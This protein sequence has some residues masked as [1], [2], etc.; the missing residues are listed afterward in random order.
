[1]IDE[2]DRK[3]LSILLRTADTPKAEIARR[4]GLAPSAVSE[5][6]RKME[7]DGVIKGYETRIDPSQTGKPILAFMFVTDAKPTAGFDTAAALAQ[8]TGV[9]ELHKLAGEDCYLLKV[10]ASDIAELNTILEREVNTVP[11][12]IRVRTTIVLKS[13]AEG[14]PHAGHS[15]VTNPPAEDTKKR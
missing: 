2:T 1:M 13:L 9:E 3:I 10:R 11:T 6:I 14:P 8:V 7:A 5:R 4:V 15:L 12:V